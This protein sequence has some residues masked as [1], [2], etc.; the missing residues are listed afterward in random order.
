MSLSTPSLTVTAH[1]ASGPSPLKAGLAEMQGWRASMEDAHV[2]CT[3]AEAD[4]GAPGLGV[5]AVFDG[6]GGAEVA[7]YAAKQVLP[8]LG[9]VLGDGAAAISRES[10]STLE[11]AL[12]AC[13]AKV[14][15]GGA[16]VR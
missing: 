8:T 16:A 14:G 6:H 12:T 5:F 7:R 10:P 13:F 3:D 4:A 1:H 11:K 15:K 2:L 9:R